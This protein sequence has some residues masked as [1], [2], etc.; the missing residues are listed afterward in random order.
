MVIVTDCICNCKSNY[1]MIITMTGPRFVDVTN[2]CQLKCCPNFTDNVKCTVHVYVFYLM[3]W[4]NLSKDGTFYWFSIIDIIFSQKL[5]NLENW[6]PPNKE[7]I[8]VSITNWSKRVDCI[9]RKYSKPALI[10]P[11]TSNATPPF[12]SDFR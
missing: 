9:P 6:T 8:E 5:S 12:R 2:D 4:T 7:S 10:W 11:L 3:I 1:N